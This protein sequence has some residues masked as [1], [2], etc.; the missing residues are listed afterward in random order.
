VIN[1]HREKNNFTEQDATRIIL[2][3]W[4]KD[5]LIFIPERYRVQFTF[6]FNV[7]CWTGARIGAFFKGGGLR[8]RDVHLA[9]QRVGDGD[10]WK[11]IYRLDQRWVKNN[12]D[13]ENIV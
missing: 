3:A 5:D 10:G 2:T 6:I 11:L 8:Y 1:K 4:T 9:L 13:P 7:Y 12:R